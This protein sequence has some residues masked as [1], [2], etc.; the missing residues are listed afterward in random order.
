MGNR[1]SPHPAP[2]GDGGGSNNS[3][4]A[5][6]AASGFDLSLLRQMQSNDNNIDPKTIETVIIPQIITQAR[7]LLTG[8]DINQNQ[9]SFMMK[10]VM[11][12]KENAMMKQ[13]DRRFDS[14]K[15]NQQQ[16][17]VGTNQ[18]GEGLFS[19]PPTSG[20]GP[21]GP[22][23]PQQQGPPMGFMAPPVR[24]GM[25]P[26][27]PHFD[28]RMGLPPGAAAGGFPMGPP[29]PHMGRPDLRRDLPPA[30]GEDLE[31]LR[32]DPFKTIS[33]DNHPRDIR[34]YEETAT[35]VMAEND[36]RELSF[37]RPK[38]P[39][40]PAEGEAPPP[41]PLT[42]RRVI[43]DG[44][45]SIVP[46]LEL[47]SS[48]YTDFVLDGVAH[49]IRIGAPTR[50]LWLDGQWYECYFDKEIRVRIGQSFH[51]VRLEGP[52]PSVHIGERRPDLCAGFVRIIHN[53][54]LHDWRKLYLD[55]K[56]QLF[57][58]GGKPHILKFAERLDTLLINEHPF[59]TSDRFGGIPIV[60]HVAG[61][62]H[63]LRLSSLPAGVSLANALV[64]RDEIGSAEDHPRSPG[65]QAAAQ[66]QQH[67]GDRF[68]SEGHTAAF[69][70]LMNIFPGQSENRDMD[71]RSESDYNVRDA[72]VP[73]GGPVNLVATPIKM[74]PSEGSS[75]SGE[76]GN[77]GTQA[78]PAVN[79]HDLWSQLL[80]AG[81]VTSDPAVEG[82][83]G[84]GAAASSSKAGIP[85][86]EVPQTPEAQVKK[87][88]EGGDKASPDSGDKK[89]V[90]KQEPETPPT[91]KG[92]VYDIK[93]IVLKSHHPSLKTYDNIFPSSI[94]TCS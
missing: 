30:D 32:H 85:G 8:G 64:P 80:G 21:M 7:H 70:R 78:S 51:N 79:V 33:I 77:N 20:P 4:E 93:K 53:G 44:D 9:F 35:C 90:V 40:P 59:R 18:V 71:T 72:P 24:P 82:G 52:P 41:P 31:L 60:I 13:A 45:E 50:E 69:D 48:E 92:P 86:L 11:I 29:P 19:T 25:M 12:L 16:Q 39:P 17:L 74:E 57:E 73:T 58:I 2:F 46:A 76:N 88:G 36:V 65:S 27:P 23:P 62:K 38:T 3:G 61:I 6:A 63:Y 37:E 54:Q 43:I 26:P 68:D 1:R 84:G 49:K 87:E 22:P 34:F 81:L 56:P 10:Q 66:Q 94:V 89:P 14:N 91:P 42:T 83:G 55:N 47:G 75:N 15:E 5:A 67:D 28:P